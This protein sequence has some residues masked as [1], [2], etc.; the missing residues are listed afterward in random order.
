MS[1]FKVKLKLKLLDAKKSAVFVLTG[2]DFVKIVITEMKKVIF[3]FYLSLKSLIFNQQK[4]NA[5]WLHKKGKN[6]VLYY[7]TSDNTPVFSRF[8]PVS[9]HIVIS[10]IVWRT[11]NYYELLS[12]TILNFNPFLTATWQPIRWFKD[13]LHN[14][15]LSEGSSYVATA[16][17]NMSGQDSIFI[18]SNFYHTP[19]Q[20]W[21]KNPRI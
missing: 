4:V 18:Q 17:F 11:P 14:C 6:Y 12:Y 19:D 20:P 21:Q 7:I 9:S 3:E 8:L 1:A 13:I 5:M 16:I 2:A 15:S 10:P